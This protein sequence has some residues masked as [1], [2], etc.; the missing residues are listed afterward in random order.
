MLQML[1][2]HEG[3]ACQTSAAQ[4]EPEHQTLIDDSKPSFLG[5]VVPRAERVSYVPLLSRHLLE[6]LPHHTY[7][8]Q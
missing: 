3:D 2:L 6:L 8:R 7:V 5:L 1:V 4:R